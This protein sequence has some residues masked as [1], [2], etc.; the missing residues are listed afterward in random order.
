[1]KL[2]L[3][4]DNPFIPEHPI[5]LSELSTNALH[6]ARPLQHLYNTDRNILA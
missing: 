1:M 6:Q 2:E 5:T 4:W 3:I